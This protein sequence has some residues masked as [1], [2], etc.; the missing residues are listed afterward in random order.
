M[1]PTINY[2]FIFIFL[3]I[4]LSILKAVEDDERKDIEM[5]SLSNHTTLH[6]QEEKEDEFI[7]F[8]YSLHTTHDSNHTNILR[9]RKLQDQQSERLSD[10]SQ[11][12]F[13]H[14]THY[15]HSGSIDSLLLGKKAIGFSSAFL[16]SYTKKSAFFWNI[17]NAILD[18]IEGFTHAAATCLIIFT[19]ADTKISSTAFITLSIQIGL[20]A[21]ALNKLNSFAEKVVVA[22]NSLALDCIRQQHLQKLNKE[23][24]QATLHFREPTAE[25]LTYIE[26]PENYSTPFLQGFYKHLTEARIVMWDFFGIASII[27]QSAG[28]SLAN[29]STNDPEYRRFFLTGAAICGLLGNFCELYLK[30]IKKNTETAEEKALNSRK[31]N[32][33]IQNTK[34]I[35]ADRSPKVST[36]INQQLLGDEN[37]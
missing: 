30:K 14:K 34:N 9:Q 21:H 10:I 31:Y 37:I 19:N 16:E 20:I 4:K 28:Y 35:Y 22:R 32:Q 7:N 18:D 2:L 26:N 6:E 23:N 3:S 25:E 12:E 15:K 29:W 1:Y 11:T 27:F 24:Q 5:G 8:P 36:P 33:I 17:C 13:S